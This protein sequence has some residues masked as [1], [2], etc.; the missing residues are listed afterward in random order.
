MTTTVLKID[1]I[2][3]NIQHKI[4]LPLFVFKKPTTIEEYNTL[5]V[6]LDQLMD[7]VREDESHPLALAMQIIGEN[8]EQYDDENFPPIGEKVSAIDMVNYLM[9]KNNL[10]QKDL[11]DIFGGQANLSKFLHGK[12][13]LAKNHIIGLKNRF[14]LSS[15]FFLN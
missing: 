8:L 7:E 2:D 5:E 9:K 4:Q 12:R 6:I 15:D 1:Y 13:P 3:Q 11:A 10:Y 14:Q